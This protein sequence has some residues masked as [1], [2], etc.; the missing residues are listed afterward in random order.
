MSGVVYYS[1]LKGE[2]QIGRKTGN[3]VPEIILGA[4]GIKPNHASIKLLKNGL[5]E[6]TV[7][8]AEAATTTMVNGKSLNPKKRNRVLNHCDRIAFNGAIIYVFK[9]PKLKRTISQ[10]VE[11]NSNKNLGVA[12][13]L[14]NAQ[15]WELVQE[16]GI[17]GIDQKNPSKE[18]LGIQDY[19]DHEI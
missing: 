3:P 4:I 7:C 5:F 14:Q 13:E 15:A 11:E 17:E 9:Y 2:I 10:K 8:D 18:N 12:I 1:L 19:A 6:L 16:T